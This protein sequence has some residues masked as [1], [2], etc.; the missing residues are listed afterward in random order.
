MKVITDYP[1][2]YESKDHTEPWGT[3]GDNNTSLPYIEEIEKH[4]GGKKIN[5]LDIGCSGGQLVVD[6][7][8]R[9][10]KSIGI[11]GSDYS[12]KA[13]RAGWAEYYQD[14][15]W[16]ADAAKPYRIE[17]DGEQVKF[18]FINSWEVI[19]HIPPDELEQFF[20]NILD[21]LKEDG[22]FVGSISIDFDDIYHVSNFEVDTWVYEILPKQFKVDVYPFEN[23]LRDEDYSFH[24]MLSHKVEETTS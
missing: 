20:Q 10:H 18:D 19:E 24:V 2:A 5:F 1:V 4:F 9:G 12:A 13:G 7:H 16:T 23:K 3:K 15:L 8:N 22:I 14:I 6:L 11:E 21:H 17:E